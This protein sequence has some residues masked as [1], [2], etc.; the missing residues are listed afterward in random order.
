MGLV[1]TFMQ[2]QLSV[3]RSRYVL[4]L[5]CHWPQGG[6]EV[7]LHRERHRVNQRD[8]VLGGEVEGR[9]VL[10]TKQGRRLP[11]RDGAFRGAWD[12]QTGWRGG[13]ENGGIQETGAQQPRVH[14][15]H[16]NHVPFFAGH[17]ARCSQ[18]LVC[19][20]PVLTWIWSR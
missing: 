10:G 8:C 11:C 3:L 20:H 9:E 12:H 15:S 18:V 13:R 1:I 4:V 19:L 7:G 6:P 5:V 14:T 17:F 16:L 2:I